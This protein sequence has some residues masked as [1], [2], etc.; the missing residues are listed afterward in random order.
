[1]PNLS[2]YIFEQNYSQKNLVRFE[3]HHSLA[4]LIPPFNA[5]EHAALNHCAVDSRFHGLRLSAI[6]AETAG[7][8]AETT[9]E[10]ARGQVAGCRQPG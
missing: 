9:L 4:K 1:M 6:T 7:R 3:R 5:D 2:I 10:W 8:M